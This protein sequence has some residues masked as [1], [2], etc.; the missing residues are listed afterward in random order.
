[1]KNKSIKVLLIATVIFSIVPFI[2]YYYQIMTGI[3]PDPDVWYLSSNHG[4]WRGGLEGLLVFKPLFILILISIFYLFKNVLK[5]RE[6]KDKK[7][8][9]WLCFL[10][11][12]QI[13]SVI[14]QLLVMTW[15]I[16]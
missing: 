10:L 12:I 14:L 6:I 7:I 8:L 3:L 13:L 5:Y 9:A 16:D 4:P 2:I 11:V 15:T 1:M